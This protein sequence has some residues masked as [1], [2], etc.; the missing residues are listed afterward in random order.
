MLTMLEVNVWARSKPGSELAPLIDFE[1]LVDAAVLECG[2]EGMVRC[3]ERRQAL[4][5]ELG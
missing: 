3:E 5:V 1:G 4:L 2:W